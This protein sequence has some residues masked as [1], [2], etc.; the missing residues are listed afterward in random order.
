MSVSEMRALLS[1]RSQLPAN[2]SDEDEPLPK[3]RKTKNMVRKA[4]I[5]TLNLD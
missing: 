5:L 3:G 1:G 4:I 2:S